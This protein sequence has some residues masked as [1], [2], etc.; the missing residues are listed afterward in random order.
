MTTPQFGAAMYKAVPADG[1]TD[2]QLYSLEFV[3]LA[4]PQEIKLSL[5]QKVLGIFYR[6]RNFPNT[7]KGA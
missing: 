5:T 7:L 2:T 4:E 6:A 3:S 1:H